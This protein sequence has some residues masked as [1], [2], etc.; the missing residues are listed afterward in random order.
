M[1]L[2]I[3]GCYHTPKDIYF[4]GN[5]YKLEESDESGRMKYS[6]KSSTVSGDNALPLY[7]EEKNGSV[8]MTYEGKTY[9]MTYDVSSRKTDIEVKYPDGKTYFLHKEFGDN[10]SVTSGSGSPEGYPELEEF[11]SFIEKKDSIKSK[12]SGDVWLGVLMFVLGVINAVNPRIS[13]YFSKGWMY[14]DVE[15]SDL[16]LGVARIGG[17]ILIAVGL[18][19]VISSFAT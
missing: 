10:V 3:G 16:Y 4:D 17:Y 8:E 11:S 13:F 1:V 6:M 18:I 9:V 12:G 5:V 19:F 2:I 7:I 15:P 14:R